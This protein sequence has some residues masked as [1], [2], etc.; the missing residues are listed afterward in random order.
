[1]PELLHTLESMHKEEDEERKF[2]AS[3]QGVNLKEEESGD[4]LT[5][6]D[7]QMRALGIDT[8]IKNDVVGLQGESASSKGFGINQ[9]LGYA[10]E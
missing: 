1:M 5:F 7:V 10:Q 6:E 3:L 2:F 4:V 9:G 8:G